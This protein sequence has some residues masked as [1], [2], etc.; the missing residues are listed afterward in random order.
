MLGSGERK[1]LVRCEVKK[2]EARRMDSWAAKRRDVGPIERVRI[3]EFRVLRSVSTGGVQGGGRVTWVM[4]G[5]LVCEIERA[6]R[7]IGLSFSKH[8]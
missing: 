1:A 6:W 4:M 7:R 8:L 3:G 5:M 2:G